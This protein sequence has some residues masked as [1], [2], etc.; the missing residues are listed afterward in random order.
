MKDLPRVS[1]F[2]LN[3]M[4]RNVHKVCS[5]QYVAYNLSNV[6]LHVQWSLPAC[7]L[8]FRY[9]E[10]SALRNQSESLANETDR[11]IPGDTFGVF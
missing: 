5:N 8:F 11:R 10:Y 2:A 9:T 6:I 7:N 3:L 4:F 1:K